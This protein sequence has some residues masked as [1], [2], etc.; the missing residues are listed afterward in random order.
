MVTASMTTEPLG[1]AQR[2]R[3]AAAE[4]A[5]VR[6]A[7]T[8]PHVQALKIERART[9]F[10]LLIWG[11]VIFCLGFTAANVQRFAAIGFSAGSLTWWTAWVLDPGVT[12]AL[13]AVLLAEQVMSTWR[14]AIPAGARRVRWM[15]LALTYTMNTWGAWAALD[16]RLILLHSVPVLIAF[17]LV[18]ESAKLRDGL[19]QAVEKAA[20]SEPVE[21]VAEEPK[22]PPLPVTTKPYPPPVIRGRPVRSTPDITKLPDPPPPINPEDWTGLEEFRPAAVAYAEEC[23]S[24]RLSRP[25]LISWF[26]GHNYPIGTAKAEKVLKLIRA[27]CTD[28]P[29]RSL[30]AVGGS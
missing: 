11:S 21:A 19:T 24:D 4:A 2:L 8:D 12:L 25:T 9:V 20:P 5:E 17:T 30:H 14:I 26:R 3:S 1:K 28:G 27:E 7:L 13:V 16:R 22:L 15:C 18:A 23:G 29:T 10:N 6:T